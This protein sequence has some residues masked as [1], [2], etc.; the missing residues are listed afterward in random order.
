M[1][2]SS[3]ADET[4]PRFTE[5]M[6]PHET[7]SV[8]VVTGAG[9]SA[10]SGIRTFR[11]S[12]PDAIWRTDP[13]ELATRRFFE[14]DPVTHWRWYLDRFAAVD[15]AEPNPAHRALATWE[16][17]HSPRGPFLLVTQ[18]IDTLHEQAGSRSLIKVHGSADRV[19]CTQYGCIHAAPAGS[20]PRSEIDLGRFRDL[21]NADN[22]PRC[23]VCRSPLRPHVL[24]FDEYY[25]EHADYQFE[26]VREAAAA[27]DVAVF[28][29]TSL[30]VGVTAL[31]LQSALGRGCDTL[32]I[33]PD[34][35][36]AMPP[37]VLPLRARAEVLLPA[38]IAASQD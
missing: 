33:D 37:S 1:S 26:R 19:R 20:I 2:R 24:F 4:L 7:D 10:A 6:A 35:P 17:I 25:G 14:R 8:L 16:R 23:P 28:I 31:I 22:L 27:A 29:G 38:W 32:L 34:P 12:E 9:V 15:T 18:N 3:A 11:G 21:P 13:M 5:L 36:T 30:S